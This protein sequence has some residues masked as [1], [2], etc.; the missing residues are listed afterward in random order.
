M[1]NNDSDVYFKGSLAIIW[2]DTKTD[3]LAVD[4]PEASSNMMSHP[5]F[6]CFSFPFSISFLSKH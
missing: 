5:E 1:L 3:D 4:S 2:M 6:C